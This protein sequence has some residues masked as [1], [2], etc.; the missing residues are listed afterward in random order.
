[1]EPKDI[2]ILYLA[3]Y[4]PET[5]SAPVSVGDTNRVY[6]EYH[7]KVFTVLKELFP[8]TV[9][10]RNPSIMLDENLSVDYI[11]SQSELKNEPLFGNVSLATVYKGK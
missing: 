6:S 4:A 5:E 9:P 3:H 11:F 8:K 1:M 7:Y 2:Q 10:C